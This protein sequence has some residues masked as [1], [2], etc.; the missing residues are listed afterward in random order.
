MK[1]VLLPGSRL[2]GEIL[3]HGQ[4]VIPVFRQGT[5][6][7]LGPL[8]DSG[9]EPPLQGRPGLRQGVQG[10]GQSL[11][12][13]LQ[14]GDPIRNALTLQAQFL[15]TSQDFHAPLILTQPVLQPLLL[16]R[17]LGQKIG[18]FRLILGQVVLEGRLFHRPYHGAEGLIMLPSQ[19]RLPARLLTAF[20]LTLSLLPEFQ[21]FLRLLKAAQRVPPFAQ[22][23]QPHFQVAGDFLIGFQ[24]LGV[25]LH[26]LLEFRTGNRPL[27]PVGGA[28]LFHNGRRL[29]PALGVLP[30]PQEQGRQ[31]RRP[32]QRRESIGS[33]IHQ[34]PRR[35]QAHNAHSHEYQGQ[36]SS[37]QLGQLLGILP[38][39]GSGILGSQAGEGIGHFRLLRL[40]GGISLLL[41]D[42]VPLIPEAAKLPHLFLG[43]HPG[44]QRSAQSLH[45]I[46]RFLRPGHGVPG[47]GYLHRVGSLLFVGQ[48][49][50]VI[51]QL[52]EPGFHVLNP[53][54]ELLRLNV[55]RFQ[56]GELL[57]Q[58]LRLSLRLGKQTGLIISA[59]IAQ[60][61]QL[62][63]QP[64]CRAAF[65]AGG[66]Q[67]VE[68]APQSL[69]L[70]HRQVGKTDE[71][72]P[73]VHRLLHAQ[74]HGS[75]VGGVQLLNR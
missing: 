45:L 16:R 26:R 36:L 13:F 46:Q 34:N 44:R 12:G 2:Q 8:G 20:P 39:H 74:K 65:V 30:H 24:F 73:A 47:L 21:H 17:A 64:V 32:R 11:I 66:D 62:S 15:G 69:V 29:P 72:R 48:G 63:R 56:L 58:L 27:L 35:Q 37:G 75:A 52:L 61:F 18:G 7:F 25:I 38:S 28:V 42:G 9:G 67:G 22:N 19:R 31:S 57:L 68:P 6:D 5:E 53:L 70:G 33:Q 14:P 54:P 49:L 23:H 3:P 41:P 60:V 40:G 59:L 4:A 51:V 55:Q 50:L 71:A 10:Y 1:H 43:L